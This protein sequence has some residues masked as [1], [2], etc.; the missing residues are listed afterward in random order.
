MVV[1]FCEINEHTGTPREKPAKKTLLLFY[2]LKIKID[3][4]SG[5]QGTSIYMY[6]YIHKKDDKHPR[7]YFNNIG[8]CKSKKAF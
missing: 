7:K 2:Y 8:K 4:A 3:M 5:T 6:T 1:I